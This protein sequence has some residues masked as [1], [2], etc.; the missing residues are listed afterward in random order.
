MSDHKHNYKLLTKTYSSPAF[1]A[2]LDYLTAGTDQFDKALHG[3]TTFVWQCEDASCGAIQK[4]ECL[5]A[6]VKLK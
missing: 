1:L 5:G 4:T 2:Q 6:E 3:V